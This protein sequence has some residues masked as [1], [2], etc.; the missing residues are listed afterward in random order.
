MQWCFSRI[1]N[2]IFFILLQN[3]NV[4]LQVFRF[5]AFKEFQ[6]LISIKL[7][8]Q[9]Y[10]IVLKIDF[11]IILIINLE[12]SLTKMINLKNYI[13]K[14]MIL[15]LKQHLLNGIDFSWIKIN[16][17]LTLVNQLWNLLIFQM[18]SIDL[19]LNCILQ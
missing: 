9:L 15:D 2:F 4:V 3:I 13:L 1:S 8:F 10:K 6:L 18:N 16:I 5:F 7:I 11:F 12:N 19:G 17:L 14:L